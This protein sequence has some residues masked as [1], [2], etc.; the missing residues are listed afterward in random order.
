M[1]AYAFYQ[2]GLEEQRRLQEENLALATETRSLLRS[3]ALQAKLHPFKDHGQRTPAELTVRYHQALSD[4]D[5]ARVDLASLQ[6]SLNQD[7]V[8]LRTNLESLEAQVMEMNAA[9]DALR[10]TAAQRV[11]RS[12]GVYMTPDMVQAKETSLRDLL[13]QHDELRLQLF[14]LDEK[15]A[16]LGVRTQ[17]RGA[18]SSETG[19]RMS[20]VDI[21]QLKV[22]NQT[23]AE[24]IE[25]RN[26]E[27]LRLRRRTVSTL[28][29]LAHVREKRHFLLN[30]VQ[31]LKREL[32]AL[33]DRT[34]K[35]RDQLTSLKNGR[36]TL[37]KQAEDS[38]DSTGLSGNPALLHDYRMRE[39]RVVTLHE[40]VARAKERYDELSSRVEQMEKEVRKG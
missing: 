3:R 32:V 34:C 22:E 39:D 24:K 7:S 1:D 6:E 37:R 13:T 12:Q 29:I 40:E 25:E 4:I 15:I 21:E 28:Q 33:D 11:E 10:V 19:Q 26:E 16:S 31:G 23:L 5:Q 35:L 17:S 36:I 9:F 2:E 14:R 18:P 20:K 30:Q 38:K 27:L 8:V